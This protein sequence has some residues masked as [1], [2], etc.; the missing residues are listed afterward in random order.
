[1]WSHKE[2]QLSLDSRLNSCPSS[3]L[4]NGKAKP[5][6][7]HLLASRINWV[8]A[9]TSNYDGLIEGAY[10]LESHGIMPPVYSINGTS[11]AL[12][13]LRDGRFFVF[14]LHGDVNTPGSVVLGKS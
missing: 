5:S 4:Q 6:E 7:A 2:L 8:A 11:Q 9:L 1:L 13:C 3:I 14:K 10:A 12:D